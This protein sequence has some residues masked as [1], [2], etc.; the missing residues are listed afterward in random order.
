[1]PLQEVC[2][3]NCKPTARHRTAQDTTRLSRVWSMKDLSI[4]VGHREFTVTMPSTGQSVTYRKQPFSRML[5]AVD[6]WQ[7]G[8]AADRLAFLAQAWK[9]A[10]HKAKELGWL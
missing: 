10:Y 3:P 7:Q 2:K 1:M 6:P 4:E 5:E 9:A 8:L